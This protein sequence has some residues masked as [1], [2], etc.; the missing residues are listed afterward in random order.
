MRR[1]LAA[2]GLASLG[3]GLA[4]ALAAS[5]ERPTQA[6]FLQHLQ[7]RYAGKAEADQAGA[8][9]FELAPHGRGYEAVIRTPDGSPPLT[10]PLYPQ[11]VRPR[12]LGRASV[13]AAGRLVRRDGGFAWVE[14]TFG[15]DAARALRTVEIR[16]R[17][18][19][20]PHVPAGPFTAWRCAQLAR[21][22]D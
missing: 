14:A 19:V 22:G 18:E 1:S 12:T 5:P 2:L 21:V 11:V 3:A 15:L 9:A 20:V 17:P 7:G 4:A 10:V 8:C 13:V 6:Q 16:M